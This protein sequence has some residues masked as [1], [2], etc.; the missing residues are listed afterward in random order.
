M[1]E[2]VLSFLIS[3]LLI[4][5]LSFAQSE[6]GRGG[7]AS[8]NLMMNTLNIS[9]S[10]MTV[11]MPPTGTETKKFNVTAQLPGNS[12]LNVTV[13]RE[14][15]VANWI[16]FNGF[17]SVGFS[18]AL[19]ETRGVNFAV[20]TSSATLG[21]YYANITITSDDGQQKKLNLTINV[22]NWFGRINTTVKDTADTSIDSA[23][24]YIFQDSDLRD[25][26]QTNTAGNF[27][28]KWLQPANYTIQ[29]SKYGYLAVNKSVTV[30]GNL[31]TENIS[32]ILSAVSPVCG[33][34]VCESGEDCSSCQADCGVCYAPST[35]I[36][37]PF[38]TP[39]IPEIKVVD[40][41]VE[42][43]EEVYL[44]VNESKIIS[45]L[46]T[47][48]GT[49]VLHRL[50]IL[51]PT[52]PTIFFN[53]TPKEYAEAIPG[54]QK[55]FLLD[56]LS[57][58]EGKAEVTIQAIANETTK[59]RKLS[60]I[61]TERKIS[62]NETELREKIESLNKIIVQT[63]SILNQLKSFGYDVRVEIARLI[64]VSQTID[65][66]NIDL[67]EKKY[68]DVPMKLESAANGIK[69]ILNRIAPLGMEQE[70]RARQIMILIV[71]FSIISF[72][73]GVAVVKTVMRRY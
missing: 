37:P 18:L 13:T 6:L 66:A 8:V 48:N 34:G 73:V 68:E 62:I 69:E 30:S 2:F 7:E 1:K 38:I 23:Y 12:G 54:E 53:I 24:V 20:E 27:L 26:G 43:P 70:I 46:I 65:E 3:F 45:V 11:Q 41:K 14:G 47:N 59:I 22:T 67:D 44:Y 25:Y 40:F 17:V 39:T 71:T 16:T 61:T 64:Q 15:S 60:I 52:L 21:L 33:N 55:L 49:A 51:P 36:T 72:V 63:A 57:T 29:A 4:V 10:Q 28:S 9:P 5:S 58:T 31:T 19:N 50:K 42:M 35:P 32:I 56:L